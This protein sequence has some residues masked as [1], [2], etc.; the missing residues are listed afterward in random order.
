MV[1]VEPGSYDADAGGIVL[2]VRL[3]ELMRKFLSTRTCFLSKRCR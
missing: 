3:E 1:K 2:D